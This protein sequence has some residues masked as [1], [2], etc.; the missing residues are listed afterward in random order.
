MKTLTSATAA[1]CLGFSTAFSMDVSGHVYDK[2]GKALSGANACLQGGAT[3]VMTGADGAFHLSGAPAS[4]RPGVPAG[5]YRGEA[6]LRQGRDGLRIE[7]NAPGLAALEWFAADGRKVAPTQSLPLAAGGNALELPHAA[8]RGPLFL[9]LAMPGFSAV[10]E[11]ARAGSAS[12]I[13]AGVSQVAK[14]AAN[15]APIE[16]SKTGYRT[17]S[18]YPASDPESNA[19]VTV[20]NQGDSVLFDGQTLNGWNSD[21]THWSV[22]NGDIAG[23][24]TGNFGGTFIASKAAFLAYRVTVTER[25]VSGSHLGLCV[26]GQDL[27]PGD[28]GAGKCLVVIP[29]NGSMW[30][31][32]KGAI[33]GAR[34]GDAGIKDT[35]WHQ[36]EMLMRPGTGE[37]LAASNGVQITYFKDGNPSRFKPGPFRLQLHANN[38]DQE[39]LYRDVVVEPNPKDDRLLSLK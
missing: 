30:D 25:R 18:Y 21:N 31:Y 27:G 1:L 13:P 15:P 2:F 36:V 33:S 17:A 9:R 29:P 11:I 38:G 14:A 32:G 6:A 24:S 35:D 12:E 39:M 7:T 16:V 34:K 8:A 10:W 22:K 37:I 4:A 26:W 23:N 5:E 19:Y 3:C 28:G 20:A